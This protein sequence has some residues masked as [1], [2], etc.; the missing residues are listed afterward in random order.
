[1]YHI[2]FLGFFKPVMWKIAS[3]RQ[4]MTDRP[5]ATELELKRFCCV[6]KHKA[7]RQAVLRS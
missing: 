5:L 4:I 3:R 6:Y 7:Q 1:M 2:Y